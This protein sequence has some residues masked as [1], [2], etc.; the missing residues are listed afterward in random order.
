MKDKID[1]LG[2]L[3]ADLGQISLATLRDFDYT[4]CSGSLKLFGT[5]GQGQLALAGPA[6]SRTLNLKLHDYRAKIPRTAAPF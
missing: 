4:S 6:G 5:E 2:G 3:K 1:A